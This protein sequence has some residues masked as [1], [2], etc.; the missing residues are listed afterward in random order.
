MSHQPKRRRHDDD[1][2]TRFDEAAA[3]VIAAGNRRTREVRSSKEQCDTAQGLLCGAISFWL[4]AHQPCGR[5]WCEPCTHI[6]T[7]EKRMAELARLLE[8]Y[9]STSPYYRTA[10]DARDVDAPATVQ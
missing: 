5:S 3:A 2:E 1:E 6:N 7:P 8:Q 9:A 4:S 10:N